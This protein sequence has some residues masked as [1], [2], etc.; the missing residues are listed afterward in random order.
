MDFESHARLSCHPKYP[1]LG[2][3]VLELPGV[4]IAIGILLSPGRCEPAVLHFVHHCPRHLQA[5]TQGGPTAIAL[6]Q[7]FCLSIQTILIS[8]IMQIWNLV[9]HVN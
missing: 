4:P 3:L 8:Q 9:L 6:V 5:N 2:I 7:R 1:S